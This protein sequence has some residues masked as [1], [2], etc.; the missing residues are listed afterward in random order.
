[1]IPSRGRQRIR[2]SFISYQTNNVEALE[3]DCR[4]EKLS[5]KAFKS[6]TFRKAFKLLRGESALQHSGNPFL[7]SRRG[8]SRIR[9]G[10]WKYLEAKA[11]AEFNILELIENHSHGLGCCLA[12]FFQFFIF[13]IAREIHKTVSRA[14]LSA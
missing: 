6:S 14:L 2:I 12:C 4:N 13:H 8:S 3:I 1:V 9:I 7:A 10:K 5:L 11:E